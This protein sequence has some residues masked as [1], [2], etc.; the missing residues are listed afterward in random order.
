MIVLNYYKYYWLL[1]KKVTKSDSD[2]TMSEYSSNGM[3]FN[4]FSKY[5]TKFVKNNLVK[6][7]NL[8]S[9]EEIVGIFEELSHDGYDQYGPKS[10]IYCL[11][12]TVH[13]HDTKK[14]NYHLYSAEQWYEKNEVVEF[15]QFITKQSDKYVD[16]KGLNDYRSIN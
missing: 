10:N 1:F 12:V 15:E 7:I 2:N 6:D 8:K 4:Y 13:D 11:Y 5:A 9:S 3:N 16:I 14:H